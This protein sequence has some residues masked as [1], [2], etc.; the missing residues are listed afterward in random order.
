MLPK[1]FTTR[2]QMKNTVIDCFPFA[3]LLYSSLP[4]RLRAEP[5]SQRGLRGAR[6][7]Y[8]SPR[9]AYLRPLQARREQ[10]INRKSW[11]IYI[12]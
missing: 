12:C 1:Q 5:P 2:M 4:Y 11:R 7:F 9:D 6:T 10:Q 8:G 3:G